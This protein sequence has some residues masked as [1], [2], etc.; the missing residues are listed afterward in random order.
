MHPSWPVL[1]VT[2]SPRMVDA[3]RSQHRNARLYISEVSVTLEINCYCLKGKLSA[4]CG[5]E[6]ELLAGSDPKRIATILKTSRNSK[7]KVQITRI[8]PAQIIFNFS[9]THSGNLDRGEGYQSYMP[10]VQCWQ[11]RLPGVLLQENPP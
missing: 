10:S 6:S 5:P 8:R 2:T 4:L 9:S 11:E 3:T 1:S 7:V